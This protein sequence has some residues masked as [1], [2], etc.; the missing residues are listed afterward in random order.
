MQIEQ[1][2]ILSELEFLRQ[3]SQREVNYQERLEILKS[4]NRLISEAKQNPYL[5]DNM[6]ERITDLSNRIKK[7]LDQSPA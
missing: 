1:K 4:V 5:N 3:R 6:L 2:S 7:N